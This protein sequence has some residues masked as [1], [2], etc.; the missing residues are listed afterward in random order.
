MEVAVALHSL[1]KTRSVLQLENL[2]LRHE[3]LVLH[4][5]AQKR[6]QLN[7]A[8]RLLWIGISR[9]CTDLRSWLVIVQ[10]EIVLGWQRKLFRAF[11]TWMI[12]HGKPGRQVFPATPEN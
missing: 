3:L 8:D 6:P 9:L 12:R 11:W 10:P 5:T 7:A 1:I 2:A 4:R